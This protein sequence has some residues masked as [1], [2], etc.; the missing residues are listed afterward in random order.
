MMI[1]CHQKYVKFRIQLEFD[2]KTFCRTK[3]LVYIHT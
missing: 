3:L 2:H 1:M